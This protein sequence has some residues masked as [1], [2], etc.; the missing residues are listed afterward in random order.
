MER[1]R[2]VTDPV[3]P[4]TNTTFGRICV[5]VS[6]AE[7]AAPREI[8]SCVDEEIDTEEADGDVDGDGSPSGSTE[9]A[10]G[11]ALPMPASVAARSPRT[12]GPA[13]RAEYPET[14]RRTLSDATGIG[15]LST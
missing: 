3:G 2:W 10:T 12:T 7:R 9:A 13:S 8:G 11:V 5:D 4:T 15:L 14:R 6:A 1:Y